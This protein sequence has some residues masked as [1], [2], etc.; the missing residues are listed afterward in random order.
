MV[1][2]ASWQDRDGATTALLSVYG[3]GRRTDESLGALEAWLLAEGAY[4][5]GGVRDE[6]L[7]CWQDEI[8]SAMGPH[9]TAVAGEF[10]HQY[11]GA[12]GDLV[13]LARDRSALLDCS[14]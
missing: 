2:A 3:D 5:R 14:R 1:L 12:G 6:V 11:V 9:A 4:V 8:D 7:S 10:V 13:G